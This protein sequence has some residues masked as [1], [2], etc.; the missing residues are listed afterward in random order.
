MR[1]PNVVVVVM[2]CVR[3]SDFPSTPD[4]RWKTRFSE[5][6]SSESIVFENAVSPSPWT[7]PS[8]ASLFSG[9]DPWQN[10]CHWK[11]DLRLDPTRPRVAQ[12]LREAG[13]R[14][15]ALCANPLISPS[16]NMTAGFD[17]SAWSSWW[18]PYL[19]FVGGSA[20]YRESPSPFPGGANASGANR[21]RAIDSLVKRSVGF[22]HKYPALLDGGSRVMQGLNAQDPRPDVGI[23]RWIEPTLERWIKE[24]APSVPIFAF[25]NLLEAHEP[26]FA[27][28]DQNAGLLGAI[29]YS[30]IRQDNI[31]YLAGEWVPRRGELKALHDLYQYSI[32]VLDDRIRSIVEVL[33][34]ADRWDNSLFILTSDHGQA[35]GE[36]DFLFHMI[37]L[38]EQ[39]IRVPLWVRM[40]RGEHGGTTARGWATL[41][42]IPYSITSTVGAPALPESSGCSLT[43]LLDRT[44]SIPVLSCSDG[45]PWAHNR[46]R[47]P[48]ERAR[49]L[50][51]VQVAA[52]LGDSKF[53][54]DSSSGRAEV[55]DLRADPNE[56]SGSRSTVDALPGS[57]SR[58]GSRAGQAIL[59]STSA[60]V[61]ADVE[62][63]LRAWGYM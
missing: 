40:P 41:T 19:R 54:L 34:N 3:A 18:E 49:S 16:F 56:E 7:L 23:A 43:D 10:G 59:G 28:P 14:T 21:T 17:H 52:Y 24:V 55:I 32:S 62:E 39:V 25:I 50:D 38:R 8:H 22:F 37:S 5:T 47:F 46:E 35:F 2:D 1:Q 63:R 44:R 13:Y 42:D 60:E 61:G 51:R 29:D 53:I 26:Y 45:I 6:L 4:S 48:A 15:L 31:G 20:P 12:V 27:T 30:R 9:L 58:A 11:G 33:K 57:V 36:H